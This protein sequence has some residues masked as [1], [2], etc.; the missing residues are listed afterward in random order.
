MGAASST[1]EDH[2]DDLPTSSG[3]RVTQGLLQQLQGKKLQHS[4]PPLRIAPRPQPPSAEATKE[5]KRLLAHDQQLHQALDHSRRVGDLLLK[6]EETELR[7]IDAM[8]QQLLQSEYRGPSRQ[9]PCRHE[10][11]QC[12]QCYE[13]NPT[14]PLSC[15]NAV[16]AYAACA[17]AAHASQAR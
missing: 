1:V 5:I 17:R 10:H 6:N 2:S 8:T 12:L 9:P 13:L 14:D 11:A 3:V 7:N 16:E 4:A 15:A